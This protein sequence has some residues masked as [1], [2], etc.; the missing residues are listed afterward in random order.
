MKRSTAKSSA[1]PRHSRPFG[2]TR[3]GGWVRLLVG[4]SVWQAVTWRLCWF[5]GYEPSGNRR[6]WLRNR[7]FPLLMHAARTQHARNARACTRR[8]AASS[9]PNPNTK[10]MVGWKAQGPAHAAKRTARPQGPSGDHHEPEFGCACLTGQHTGGG[11]R[12]LREHQPH[13]HQAPEAA[14]TQTKAAYALPGPPPTTGGAPER[15]RAVLQP[16]RHQNPL[17]I[18]NLYGFG[19]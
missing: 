8:P 9:I 14:P 7:N 6:M 4:L 5:A 16:P 15:P 12:P 3:M 10:G 2:S 1:C 19:G 17:S 13:G 18:R 11:R